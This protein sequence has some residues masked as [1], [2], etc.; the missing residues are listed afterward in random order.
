VSLTPGTWHPKPA[1]PVPCNLF[2]NSTLAFPP[3]GVYTDLIYVLVIK[4]WLHVLNN[5]LD[6]ATADKSNAAAVCARRTD[7]FER[8]KVCRKGRVRVKASL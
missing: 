3:R 8:A 2:P 5:T 4:R 6:L 1:V 7:S